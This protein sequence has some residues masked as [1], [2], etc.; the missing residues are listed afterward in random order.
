MQLLFEKNDTVG[1]APTPSNITSERFKSFCRTIE[2]TINKIA[3]RFTSAS[4]NC[5]GSNL[6][7]IDKGDNWRGVR[8][9]PDA[10]INPPTTAWLSARIGTSLDR[11]HVELFIYGLKGN[12][13]D[14]TFMITKC[15][16]VGSFSNLCK[17]AS[18]GMCLFSFVDTPGHRFVTVCKVQGLIA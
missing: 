9:W 7:T 1:H 11:E 18:D 2:T 17:R 16:S 10:D 5:F 13:A 4:A 15:A 6:P 3:F 12:F 8:F 14:G